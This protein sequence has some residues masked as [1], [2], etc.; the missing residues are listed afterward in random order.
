MWIGKKVVGNKAISAS[1]CCVAQ[2]L[3]GPTVVGRI[4]GSSGRESDINLTERTHFAR[5][6]FAEIARANKPKACV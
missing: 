2:T 6:G 3:V 4:L 5:R 1:L